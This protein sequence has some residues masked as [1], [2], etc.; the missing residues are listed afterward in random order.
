MPVSADDDLD[1]GEPLAGAPREMAQIV[2]DPQ[3]CGTRPV[4]PSHQRDQVG[5]GA[6]D[7]HRQVL[8][9][10]VEAVK[11]DQLLLAMRGIVEGI[12]VERDPRRWRGEGVE[13]LVTQHVS[14]PLEV[15]DRDGVL[16]TARG[17][18]NRDR[19]G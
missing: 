7:R 5:L 17:G 14:Q 2:I 8:I 18:S 19:V 6:G 15:G 10:L 1:I 16:P 13:E 3:P 11:E 9:L 4:T 12:D